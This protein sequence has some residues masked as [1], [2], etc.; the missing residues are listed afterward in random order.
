MD[1]ADAFASGSGSDAAVCPA[2]RSARGDSSGLPEASYIT[3]SAS[4]LTAGFCDEQH[5]GSKA[6]IKCMIRGELMLQITS[7]EIGMTNSVWPGQP[8]LDSV[9]RP[10]IGCRSRQGLWFEDLRSETARAF[11]KNVNSM[12]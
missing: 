6:R 10:A 3:G 1:E 2:G 4:K 7:D 11:S 8:R 12:W 9:D 5:G